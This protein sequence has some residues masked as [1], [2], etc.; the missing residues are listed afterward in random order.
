MASHDAGKHLAVAHGYNQPPPPQAA[1][2]Y[3]QPPPPQA[4]VSR[5]GSRA[6]MSRPGSRADM[7]ADRTS[8]VPVIENEFGP[9]YSSMRRAPLPNQRGD[10]RQANQAS[11]MPR[12]GYAYEKRGANEFHNAAYA[13]YPDENIGTM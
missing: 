1:H 5:S 10:Q 7:R 12:N 8:T 3:N 13:K 11:T 6:D 4:P 2:G 9:D